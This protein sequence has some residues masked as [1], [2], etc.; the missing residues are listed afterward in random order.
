MRNRD[1]RVAGALYALAAIGGVFALL[2]RPSQLIVSD[3]A[4]A[5]AR[6][7][8]A[9]E[10]LMRLAVASDPVLGVVWIL[11]VLALY[12]LL[13]DVDRVQA[14]LMLTLGG[15]MQA[16]LYFVNAMNYGAALELVTRPS[17]FPAFSSAQRSDL[18]ML[19]LR[20]HHDELL[21]SLLLAG[22]WLVPFGI[23]VFK[24]GFLPK[25]I[26]V[27]LVIDAFGWIA[28]FL[29]DTLAPLYSATV[30]NATAPLRP[31]EVAIALWLLIFGARPRGH[32]ADRRRSDSG[33]GE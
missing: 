28:M 25:I 20:L 3:N 1:A 29:S 30:A 5:T 14:G 33:P 18:A 13:K 7:I 16:P 10:F 6:A 2:Y 15:F 32:A 19:F 17:L 21:A 26:G 8:A 23:L 4:T 12:Q 22:L 31:A 27:W 24:S 11:V 9:H